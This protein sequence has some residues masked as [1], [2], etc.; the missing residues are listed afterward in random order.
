[1]SYRSLSGL[2]LLALAA[3]GSS[4]GR[5]ACETAVARY[6]QPTPEAAAALAQELAKPDVPAGHHDHARAVAERSKRQNERVA[7]LFVTRCTE[8]RWSAAMRRCVATDGTGCPDLLPRDQ[9]R[10]F[11]E[12]FTALTA[13]LAA[14]RKTDRDPWNAERN[15]T[16]GQAA[17]SIMRVI[18][19][20]DE[21]RARSV[22]MGA[23][24]AC[25]KWHFTAVSCFAD[26]TTTAALKSCDQYLTAEQ[27]A[28]LLEVLEP[29]PE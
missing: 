1:M 10:K 14:E 20:S 8:D 9:Y 27:Q 19:A 22:M 12:Q 7:Q 3:C 15:T 11:D 18:A 24:G 5:R 4:D 13:E 2:A 6:R 17:E 25:M 16:C 23:M 21:G 28:A 26:A 29:A